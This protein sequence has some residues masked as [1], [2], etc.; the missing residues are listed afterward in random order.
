MKPVPVTGLCAQYHKAVELIGRRWTGAIV[1]LLL[2]RPQRYN[3]LQDSIPGISARMLSERL[4]ELEDEQIVR[5]TVFPDTPVRVEYAL[6]DKG[7][8]LDT[9]ILALGRWAT[10]WIPDTPAGTAR[11]TAR[12]SAASSPSL[13]APRR[14]T[15]TPAR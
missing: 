9:A 13:P 2:D 7:R 4:R 6:T 10:E 5:R 1:R 12:T 8:S 14:R 11:P 15:K 3:Q